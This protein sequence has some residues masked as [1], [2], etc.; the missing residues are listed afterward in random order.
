MAMDSFEQILKYPKAVISRN[1]SGSFFPKGKRIYSQWLL[2]NN[3]LY[4]YCHYYPA[5]AQ[6]ATVA[7]NL[8]E[9]TTRDLV[10]RH[11]PDTFIARPTGSLP[12]PTV[13]EVAQQR[14]QV[15]EVVPE[16][17]APLQRSALYTLRDWYRAARD[18]GHNPLHL[19]KIKQL[20]LSVKQAN[21]KGFG[22]APNLQQAMAQD[23]TQYQA[24]QQRG[25]YVAQASQKICQ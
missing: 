11:A 2:D 20:G 19:E 15:N 5:F 12:T 22:L 3:G 14:Q 21:G 10:L 24:L 4:T 16:S 8:D 25:E 17:P 7:N 13:P 23:L 6:L 1:A 9:Q 18:L